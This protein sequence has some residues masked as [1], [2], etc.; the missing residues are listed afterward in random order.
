MLEMQR[1][2][3]LETLLNITLTIL[4][5]FSIE[6]IQM[7]TLEHLT[8]RVKLQNITHAAHNTKGQGHMSL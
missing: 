2:K 3:E 8:A 4:A 5:L 7:G 1:L 6:F